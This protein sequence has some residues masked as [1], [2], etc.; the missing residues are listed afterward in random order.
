MQTQV[1]IVGAGPAGLVLA[2][3]LEL[4]G[5]SSLVLKERSRSSTSGSSTTHRAGRQAFEAFT[6]GS[7][8]RWFAV[9]TAIRVAVPGALFSPPCALSI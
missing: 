3:L 2:R 6:K 4:R 8:T 7:S 1:A 5:I 9:E